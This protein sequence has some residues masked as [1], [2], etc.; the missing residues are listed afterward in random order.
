MPPIIV[1]VSSFLRQLWPIV[2]LFASKFGREAYSIAKDVV[3]DVAT[4][5]PEAATWSDEQRRTYVVREVTEALQKRYGHIPGVS[6]VVNLAVEF[7][8]GWLR[9]QFKGER[10]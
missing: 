5:L 7:A 9:M 3:Y 1:A 6:W 8:V 2:K 10:A 4:N